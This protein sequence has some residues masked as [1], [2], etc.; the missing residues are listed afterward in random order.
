MSLGEPRATD[1]LDRMSQTVD[2]TYQDREIAALTGEWQQPTID[3]SMPHVATHS[4]K[5]NAKLGDPTTLLPQGLTV[6]RTLSTGGATLESTQ[7]LAVSDRVRIMLAVNKHSQV[8]IS[9]CGATTEEAR[10]AL[11]HVVK[12]VPTDAPVDESKIDAWVWYLGKNGPSSNLTKLSVPTWAE[13]ERNYVPKVASHIDRLMALSKPVAAGKIILWHGPPGTGKTTALRALGRHWKDWCSFQYIADPERLFDDPSYLMSAAT[14][15][16]AFNPFDEDL[17]EEDVK[18]KWKLVVA[19]DSDEF[20]KVDAREKS[21]AALSR[22][23]NF[24]DGILGQSSDTL[25]LLTTN[26]P[27]EKLH[28]AVTRPGRCLSQIEFQKFTP[29]QATRW[30]GDRQVHHDVTLAEMIDM[31]NGDQIATGV[32]LEAVGQYL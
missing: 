27:V 16:H 17:E 28:P 4:V 24:S 23:L 15:A 11:L 26:E 25:I 8:Q 19:E 2:A 1:L 10:E 5:G 3:G 20:L 22:L 6:I 18:G 31:K 30:F 9:V 13:I 21:G 12:C 29:T 7:L 32:E 14:T